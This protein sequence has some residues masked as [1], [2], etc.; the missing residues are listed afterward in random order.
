MAESRQDYPNQFGLLGWPLGHSLSP[1]IHAAALQAAGLS[2][3]YQLYPVPPLPDGADLLQKV[4]DRFRF[5]ELRGL[6]VTI[7]HKQ[8]V[9]TLLDGLTKTAAAIGAVNLIYKDGER[10]MG[11][12]SDAPALLVDLQRNFALENQVG[13][14][15]VLGAGGAA[16]AAV[17]ALLQQGWQIT[18]AGRRMEAA[19]QLVADLTPVVKNLAQ[20]MVALP[21]E[22]SSLAKMH[23]CSLL[24]NATPMGMLPLADQTPWPADLSLPAGAYIYDMVYNPTETVLIRSGRAAGHPTANGLGMLVEQAARS[25]ECWTGKAA[26]RTAMW[27]AASASLDTI[28]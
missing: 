13:T 15:L 12:N 4:F 3:A 28:G 9:L 26:S 22:R 6:N 10:L 19:C 21:L 7:P 23:T 1:Q 11:D 17:Y 5:S 8:T 2:G 16:R 18:V 27:A 14:A 20:S 25:F 24:I